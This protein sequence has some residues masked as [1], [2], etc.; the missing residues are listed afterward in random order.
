M[1]YIITGILFVGFGYLSFDYFIG[2]Y[3]E[4][5]DGITNDIREIFTAPILV[6]LFYLVYYVASILLFKKIKN[7]TPKKELAFQFFFLIVNGLLSLSF[8][9]IFIWRVAEN[10]GKATQLLQVDNLSLVTAYASA[11]LLS[12]IIFVVVRIKW[13]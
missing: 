3:L 10:P 7:L 13:R 9:K 4:V 12:L 1:I 2:L 11:A 8:F 6:A 5:F